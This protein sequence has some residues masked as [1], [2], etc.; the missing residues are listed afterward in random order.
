MIFRKNR[1]TM[2]HRKICVSGG[3]TRVCRPQEGRTV[4]F[5][6]CLAEIREKGGAECGGRNILLI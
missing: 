4:V 6:N 2:L 1:Q 5:R 3:M